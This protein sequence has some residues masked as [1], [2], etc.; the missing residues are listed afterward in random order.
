MIRIDGAIGEGGG[1][2]LRTALA[3]SLCTGRAFRIERIRA[4]RRRPGLQP[5]HLAAVRAAATIARASVQGAEPDSQT[6][7]FTPGPVRPGNHEFDIGTAGSTTLVLQ[8]ILPPLM[9]A[10]GPSRLRIRGGTHNPLAPPFEF[11]QFAWR[12]LIERMGPEIALQLE[13]PGFYPHGGGLLSAAITPS[14]RLAPLRLPARGPVHTLRAEALL[15]HLP[16]HIAERELAILQRAFAI[17]EPQRRIRMDES[18]PGPGNA[19]SLFVMAEHVTEVFTAIGRRGLPAEKVAQQ[20]VDAA[21]EYL[22]ADV[23]VGRHLADQ[24]LLPIALA[25]EGHFVTL[26]PSRHTTTNITIIRQF[27]DIEIRCEAIDSRRWQ[28]RMHR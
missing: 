7:A 28:I 2:I 25:G 1:Q 9:L 17:P 16:R 21:R 14:P 11:L 10:S 20:V 6:L 4:R 13:R 22:D 8:T 3:L 18:A 19:V 26:P 15:C 5:Q 23:P 12:P 24:L 27:L